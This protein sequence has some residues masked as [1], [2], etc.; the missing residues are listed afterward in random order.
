MIRA[1]RWAALALALCLCAPA[2]AAW[3]I[4]E[5]QDPFGAPAHRAAAVMNARGDQ[6][7][8]FADRF[9]NGWLRFTL[10]ASAGEQI[11]ERSLPILTIDQGVPYEPAAM[12]LL[13][14]GLKTDLHFYRQ[15]ATSV[16]FQ[17]FHA[18][19]QWL[20]SKHFIGLMHG[21]RAVVQYLCADGKTARAE[22]S[23]QGAGAA[24]AQVLG[25]TI[26]QDPAAQARAQARQRADTAATEAC[27]THGLPKARA[28]QCHDFAL[29]C[30]V[31]DPS[32]RDAQAF[33]ECFRRWRTAKPGEL[34]PQ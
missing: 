20:R 4:V 9:G 6:L 26:D 11:A 13:E 5:D 2:W 14:D 19:D 17:V 21:E 22:F 29:L 8:V 32:Q 15:D 16:G 27:R 25:I 34:P 24:I 12:Q 10:A 18:G 7:A 33:T 28:D 31:P 30:G 1:V 23:L 3:T